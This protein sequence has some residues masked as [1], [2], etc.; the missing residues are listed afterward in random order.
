MGDTTLFLQAKQFVLLWF[1]RAS[2]ERVNRGLT[3]VGLSKATLRRGALWTSSRGPS[4]FAGAANP[5][6][7]QAKTST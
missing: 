2:A 5:P 7:D 4:S 3:S 6:C 1:R